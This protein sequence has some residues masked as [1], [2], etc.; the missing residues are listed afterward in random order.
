MIM[1]KYA[2]T[3]CIAHKQQAC[4]CLKSGREIA[5]T[6]LPSWLSSGEGSL[7][8]CPW[9]SSFTWWTKQNKTMRAY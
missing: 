5:E 2:N 7:L 4:V 3:R 8:C 9:H 6:P 1:L